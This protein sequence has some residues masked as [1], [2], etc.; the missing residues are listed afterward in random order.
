[1]ERLV[2]NC[3]IVCKNCVVNQVQWKRESGQ[4]H[5]KWKWQKLID[6]SLNKTKS[7]FIWHIFIVYLNSNH[8]LF[9]SIYLTVCVGYLHW[10]CT[11]KWYSPRQWP[12]LLV[13]STGRVC[14]LL[15]PMGLMWNL[16]KGRKAWGK[17]LRTRARTRRCLSPYIDFFW[18]WIDQL[19]HKKNIL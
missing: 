4:R 14:W 9:E 5:P 7:V 12:I 8:S 2:H 11:N 16:G 6:N 1:M 13:T 18:I 17:A 19:R 10:W 15:C 3:S